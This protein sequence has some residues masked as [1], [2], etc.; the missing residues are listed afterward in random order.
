MNILAQA[1]E[2]YDKLDDSME[3]DIARY[4][5]NGY[6][7]VTPDS[8]L[9]GKAVRKDGGDP[10]D[11]WNVTAPDSWF[12]KTAIGESC[13]SEFIERIPYPLPFV[14]WQRALKNKPVIWFDYDQIN[15]RKQ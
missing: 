9:L 8:L 12:V 7:F 15:R 11:Q 2:F 4:M 5:A 1:K 13:I 6:V 3:E 10:V 14:G